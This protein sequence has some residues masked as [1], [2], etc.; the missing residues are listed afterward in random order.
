MCTLLV[1]LLLLLLPLLLLRPTAST[2]TNASIA[3]TTNA[4]DIK[5]KISDNAVRK[6]KLNQYALNTYRLS[7]GR[8]DNISGA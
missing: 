4:E 1:Q 2:A 6:D 8:T 3:T 5:V 7:K